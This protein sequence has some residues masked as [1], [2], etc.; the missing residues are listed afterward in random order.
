MPSLRDIL[1]PP[2]PYR[3]L[4]FDCDGTLAD[5]MPTHF[6]AWV[7]ALRAAGGDITEE[8]FYQMAGVPTDVIIADLNRDFGY[9][10]DVARTHMDKER[11]YVEMVESVTEIQAVADIA[12]AHHGKVPMAVASGGIRAVVER[13]LTAT[14]LL[15]LFDTVVCAEDVTHGK[16]APDMFLLAAERLGVAPADCI[17]YEDGDPGLEAARRA[18]MRSVDVRVLW[19]QRETPR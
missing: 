7:A 1:A 8:R 9:T 16:P 2:K 10:M 15:G 6:R 19:G 3:A 18:G 13:T 4:I 11:R 14:G 17:V 5:T 12:R